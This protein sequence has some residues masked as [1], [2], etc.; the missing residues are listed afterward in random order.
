M[1][2]EEGLNPYVVMF[3]LFFFLKFPLFSV[4]AVPGVRHVRGVVRSQEDRAY[5]EYMCAMCVILASRTT[6]HLQRFAGCGCM[7]A[8]KLWSAG[9]MFH[10]LWVGGPHGAER[11]VGNGLL[12]VEGDS[13]VTHALGSC[14]PSCPLTRSSDRY[15]R[16]PRPPI[17][18]VPRGEYQASSG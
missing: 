9:W 13:E 12:L 15:N 6:R 2:G 11:P 8:V 5:C 14:L 16:P 7:W 3:F 4:P 17:S 18:P 1:S 10:P